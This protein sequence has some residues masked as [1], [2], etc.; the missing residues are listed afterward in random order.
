MPPTKTII[1][2]A[3]TSPLALWQTNYV[4][5]KLEEAWPG[6]VCR[7]ETFVTQGDKTLDKPLPE[8][9]GKGLFTAELEA[10]LMHGRIDIAVHSLK[11]LPVADTNGLIVGAI[12]PRA[13]AR[14][15][16]VAREKWTLGNL[17]LGAT[18]GTSSLRRQAQLLHA[19]PDLNI[20]SIRGNVD[21]R[22]RKVQEGQYDA[23]ILAA[24][25]LTRLG[26]EN[27]IAQYLP[28]DIMLPAPGQGALAV[29]CRVE[30]TTVLSLLAAVE[31]AETRCCVEA[32]RAFL[33]GLGSGCS[34]PVAAYATMPSDKIMLTGLVAAGDGRRVIEVQG[35]GRD[36]LQLG[37]KLA[38][39]ALA[40]GAAALLRFSGSKS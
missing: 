13:D 30:D 32:E 34:L 39:K 14:D 5:Q 20:Q 7:L 27:H 22:L 21:T 1:I 33:D 35:H 16:L 36:P 23:T 2:G 28:L 18:V 8:I 24:A 29:Q 15:V 10:A 4:K 3:R 40:Q 12:S 38:E 19:R 6:L 11:D 17:P 31:D 26:L 25:G 37:R 9:G